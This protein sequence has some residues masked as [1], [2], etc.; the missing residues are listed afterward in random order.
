MISTASL[1]ISMQKGVGVFTSLFISAL[2]P[3]DELVGPPNK[4]HAAIADLLICRAAHGALSANFDPLIEQWSAERK[5]AMQGALNGA[6]AVQFAIRSNP[7]LK[8]HGCL[9]RKKEETLWTQGQLQEAPIADRVANCSAWMSVNLPGKDLLVVGFWTDWSYFNDVLAAAI[10]V[11][12]F[13]SVTVVDPAAS[14]NLQAKAPALWNRL[15]VAGAPFSHVQASGADALDELRTEF[16]KV[17]ARKFFQL[18]MPFMSPGAPPCNSTALVPA[19][20]SC[21]QLYDLRRDAEG[22]PYNRAAKQKAPPA[23][24]AKAAFTNILLRQ[25]GATQAGSFYTHGGRTIRV[26]NGAGQVLE[27]VRESYREPSS[28]HQADIVICAG[29]DALGTPGN[30][31]S[32]GRGASIVRPAR[33]GTSRWLTFDDA[34]A[35][36]GL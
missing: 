31:I 17:W 18:G 30:I 14:A 35:E 33:G 4:G 19:T 3:W 28:A 8:L 34:R 13:S 16:S 12:N 32:A 15:A 1:G 9:N 27:T 26:V 6:E 7:L 29:A 22:L 23:T 20:L 36:L 10:A 21:D 25:A 24:A 11:Q 2:V 5:V